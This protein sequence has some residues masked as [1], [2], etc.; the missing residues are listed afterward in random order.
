M[1]ARHV[2][3]VCTCM[4]YMCGYGAVAAACVQPCGERQMLARAPC[5]AHGHAMCGAVLPGVR[6]RCIG[7]V[8]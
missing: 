4:W 1:H 2:R 5:N 6:K 7:S 3:P 8:G